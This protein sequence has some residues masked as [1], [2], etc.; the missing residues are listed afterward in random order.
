MFGRKKSWKSVE[1]EEP[2]KAVK[3]H[4]RCNFETVIAIV[5]PP[6][7]SSWRR[8]SNAFPTNK[9]QQ[10]QVENDLL[11]MLGPIWNCDKQS[12]EYKGPHWLSLLG[13]Q[14]TTLNSVS[15]TPFQTGSSSIFGNTIWKYICTMGNLLH[16][17][18]YKTVIELIRIYV[19][20]SDIFK[21][22][23]SNEWIYTIRYRQNGD[24]DRWKRMKIAVMTCINHLW[25]N[26]T[27]FP[28]LQTNI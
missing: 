4:Q 2:S 14:H 6:Y 1:T 15:F 22:F 5:F 26:K 21:E 27:W 7:S 23:F 25:L 3:L 13:Q 10:Q 28:I 18:F 12:S 20:V 8:L 11:R 16:A 19:S 24:K 9:Q 17:R